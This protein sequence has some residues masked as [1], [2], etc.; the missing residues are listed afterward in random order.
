MGFLSC[1]DASVFVSRAFF[2]FAD[3]IG[4]LREE[5]LGRHVDLFGQ[6]RPP[7]R[8]GHLDAQADTTPVE[9]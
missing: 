9:S 1:A 7:G 6:Q 4:R 8:A 5:D 2:F 3:D